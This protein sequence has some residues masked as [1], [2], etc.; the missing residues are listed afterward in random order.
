MYYLL[1]FQDTISDNI[2]SSIFMYALYF[3]SVV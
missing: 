2:V 3:K 1:K